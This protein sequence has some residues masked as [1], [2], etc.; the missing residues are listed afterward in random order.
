MLSVVYAE[1]HR[2]AL[3]AEFHHAECCY[4]ECRHAE[5]GGAQMTRGQCFRKLIHP[6]F[7]LAVAF[8]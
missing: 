6:Q 2:L 7:W 8:H 3:Y 4:A 1:C 5:C